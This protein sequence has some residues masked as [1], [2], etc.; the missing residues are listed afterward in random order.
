M[1]PSKQALI[2][3]LLCLASGCGDPVRSV[4]EDAKA[5]KAQARDAVSAAE[6][7][8]QRADERAR[9]AMKDE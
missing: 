9:G 8:A 5:A 2:A 6:E 7:A 4:D 1:T 3:I